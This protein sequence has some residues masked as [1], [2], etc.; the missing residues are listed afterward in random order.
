MIGSGEHVALWLVVGAAHDDRLDRPSALRSL[1]RRVQEVSA[2]RRPELWLL[3]DKIVDQAGFA[4]RVVDRRSRYDDGY[5]EAADVPV[6]L[7]DEHDAL[8]IVDERREKR[9]MTFL[10][11]GVRPVEDGRVTHARGALLRRELDEAVEI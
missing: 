8:R 1:R 4:S 9:T 6:V 11:L 5:H 2:D 3:D 10:R 7:V